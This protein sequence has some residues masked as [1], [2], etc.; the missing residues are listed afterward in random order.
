[1]T[2]YSISPKPATVNDSDGRL[3]RGFSLPRRAGG[4]VVLAA[5][6]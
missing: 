3:P 6:W 2:T 5:D 4:V 1:M